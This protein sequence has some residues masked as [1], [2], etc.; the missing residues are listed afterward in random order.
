MKLCVGAQKRVSG[1][2]FRSHPVQIESRAQRRTEWMLGCISPT[3]LV[4]LHKFCVH[5]ARIKHIFQDYFRKR[6]KKWS[7]IGVSSEGS[8]KFRTFWGEIK[9]DCA[10]IFA[11]TEV[12]SK[13]VI[14]KPHPGFLRHHN[15]WCTTLSKSKYIFGRQWEMSSSGHRSVF[16]RRKGKSLWSGTAT[17]VQTFTY[18]FRSS[19]WFHNI[20][21]LDEQFH[22]IAPKYYTIF[23]NCIPERRCSIF[24]RR[25]WDHFNY[26]VG[27]RQ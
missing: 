15:V 21:K 26:N 10:C 16:T 25:S 3:N 13:K 9:V 20:T 23:F 12:R 11:R 14:K 1:R 4:A 18:F 27:V 6:K 22:M 24:N 5:S 7:A 8:R 2:N 17:F 19:D